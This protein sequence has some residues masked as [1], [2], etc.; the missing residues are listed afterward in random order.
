M[1]ITTSR[2]KCRP[3][4]P[5]LAVRVKQSPDTP[6]AT[7]AVSILPYL[8]YILHDCVRRLA[9]PR[10]YSKRP[11]APLKCEVNNRLHARLST[12]TRQNAHNPV[13]P[14]ARRASPRSPLQ[15]R[16]GE[17]ANIDATTS[18]I[19]PHSLTVTLPSR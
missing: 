9:S 15:D 14:V 13:A 19:V 1:P 16:R 2:F 10:K 17:R 11:P 6:H 5:T 4:L 18:P 8:H 7:K 3:V 12:E